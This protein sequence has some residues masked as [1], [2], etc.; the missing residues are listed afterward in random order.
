MRS[1]WDTSAKRLVGENP[2][3]FIKWLLPGA[4]FKEKAQSKPL[5]LNTREREVD[6]LYEILL[7]GTLCLVHIEFQS[8]FDGSMA[9]RMWEYNTLATF[10][11]NRPTCSFVIYL[12]KCEVPESLYEW[13]FPNGEVI[14]HFHFKVIKLWEIPALMLKQTGLVGIF[15]LIVLTKDGKRPEVVEEVITSLQLHEGE[16]AKELIS[17]TYIFAT[18]AFENQGDLAWLKRRINTM[19]DFLQESWLYQEI[20]QK[21]F[22]KGIEKEREEELR[23]QRQ[24][25]MTII[26]MHFP[27]ITS[28]AQKQAEAIKDPEVLQGLIFKVLAAEAEEEAT[29]SLLAVSQQ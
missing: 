15:P 18:L 9:Q 27:N 10:S 8:F 3:H 1:R 5:N 28:L 11:Y 25:L 4:E 2:E 29:L 12:K 21:G 6:A 26:H 19:Q 22:D 7:Y 14:H 20:M 13:T 17:L 24:L 16:S 23:R